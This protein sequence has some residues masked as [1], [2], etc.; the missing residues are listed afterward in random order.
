MT[1][2]PNIKPGFV[3][4][5]QHDSTINISNTTTI[6]YGYMLPMAKEKLARKSMEFIVIGS[7]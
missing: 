3:I 7:D 1:K 2:Q 5:L 6:V 4:D